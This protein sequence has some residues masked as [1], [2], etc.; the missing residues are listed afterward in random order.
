MLVRERGVSDARRRKAVTLRTQIRPLFRHAVVAVFICVGLFLP[1]NTVSAFVSHIYRRR[2]RGRGQRLFSLVVPEDQQHQ[3]PTTSA[4]RRRSPFPPRPSDL[5]MSLAESQMELLAYSLSCRDDRSNSKVRSMALYFPRENARTGQ[6]EFFSLLHYPNPSKPRVFI[7]TQDGMTTPTFPKSLT[8]LPGFAHASS[9]LPDYPMVMPGASARVG[10]VEEVMCD[11]ETRSAALSVPLLSGPQTIGALIVWA[12]EPGWTDGEKE[13]V[14]RTAQSMALALSMDMD[15]IMLREQSEE[16][17]VALSDSLHQIKNPLQALRIYGKLLQ[18]QVESNAGGGEKSNY[19]EIAQQLLIQ[20]ERVVDLLNPMDSIANTL[21][22]QQRPP[23]ALPPSR[24]QLFPKHLSLSSVP[25]TNSSLLNLDVP[26]AERQGSDGAR[27]SDS[28]VPN[29]MV[30]GDEFDGS[31]ATDNSFA[32][33]TG[34]AYEFSGPSRSFSTSGVPRAYEFGTAPEPKYLPSAPCVVDTSDLQMSFVND[35]LGSILHSYEL[36]G[37]EAG[38]I[39]EIDMNGDDLPGVMISP[40]SLEEAVSNVLDNAVKYVVLAPSDSPFTRNPSPMIRVV[41]EANSSNDKDGVTIW[42]IDNGPGVAFT[43]RDKIFERGYRGEET[44]NR[45]P[46]T[47]IGLNISHSLVT[48]M[49]GELDLL[50]SYDDGPRRMGG[51]VFRFKLYR[52]PAA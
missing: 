30:F 16:I 15:R 26:S 11:P 20:S 41:V 45:A 17:S 13:Q 1:P 7:T 4:E 37:R 48:R 25:S 51:A 29:L 8:A 47:G 42:I 35:V 44:R 10:T 31:N 32:T 14:S 28:S 49:G 50:E 19:A 2:G 5:F 40:K 27:Q 36:L 43:D 21:D 6:L 46:G 24:G 34:E 39:V 52:N 33:S 22:Q 12:R 3:Q 38:I 18:R 9:V 23:L